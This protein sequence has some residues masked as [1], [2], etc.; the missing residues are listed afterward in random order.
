MPS[1]NKR[2]SSTTAK[3]KSKGKGKAPPSREPLPLGTLVARRYINQSKNQKWDDSGQIVEVVAIANGPRSYKAKFA[4]GVEPLSDNEA[5]VA[6]E[7]YRIRTQTNKLDI[8]R[9]P[10]PA[11]GTKI[12]KRYAIDEDGSSE[13]Y[14]GKVIAQTRRSTKVRFDDDGVEEDLTDDELRVCAFAYKYFHPEPG[15]AETKVEAKKTAKQGGKKVKKEEDE[16]EIPPKR[17]KKAKMEDDDPKP[18]AGKKKRLSAKQKLQQSAEDEDSGTEADVEEDKK[19]A[20]RTKRTGRKSATQKSEPEEPAGSEKNE[21]EKTAASSRQNRR[22]SAPKK[23]EQPA[24]SEQ[25]EE[26]KTAA[27]PNRRKASKKPAADE[28][29]MVGI[30]DADQII[31]NSRK[32]RGAA[33]KTEEEEQPDS[34]GIKR[35]HESR[36]VAPAK[37]KQPPKPQENVAVS[38]RRQT[39]TSL[40][41]ELDKEGISPATAKTAKASNKKGDKE[42]DEAP[43]PQED[44]TA[45]APKRRQ[46]RTSL[47]SEPNKSPATAKTAKAANKKG[48][49]EKEEP[50]T[51]KASEEPAASP[52][53]KPLARGSRLRSSSPVPKK[54]QVDA[55]KSNGKARTT[56]SGGESASKRAST[57]TPDA[58]SKSRSSSRTKAVAS[59]DEKESHDSNT[60]ECP[61][62]PTVVELREAEQEHGNANQAEQEAKAAYEQA[63]KAL[64]EAQERLR[65]AAKLHADSKKR[66]QRTKR[67]LEEASRSYQRRKRARLMENRSVALTETETKSTKKWGDDTACQA[68]TEV[69]KEYGNEV[70][71]DHTARTSTAKV[72]EGDNACESGPLGAKENNGSET[73]A[74]GAL[75]TKVQREAVKSATPTEV[76][77]AKTDSQVE[78]AGLLDSKDAETKETT[79]PPSEI[80]ARSE[81]QVEST[82]PGDPNVVEQ[83][84][85]SSPSETKPTT[86]SQVEPVCPSI[87]APKVIQGTDIID[88]A[89]PS[90]QTNTTTAEMDVAS[91]S[92]NRAKEGLEVEGSKGSQDE[93]NNTPQPQPQPRVENGNQNDE[94]S[95]AMV[96]SQSSNNSSEDSPKEHIMWIAAGKAGVDPSDTQQKEDV[97]SERPQVT[98]TSEKERETEVGKQMAGLTSPSQSRAHEAS[99]ILSKDTDETGS[100]AVPSKEAKSPSPGSSKAET[101]TNECKPSCTPP[102]PPPEKTVTGA[103]SPSVEAAD[104][105]E[106]ALGTPGSESKAQASVV[107]HD[108]SFAS[109]TND[110]ASSSIV[111][112]LPALGMTS[113]PAAVVQT[114]APSTA[115]KAEKITDAAASSKEIGMDPLKTVTTQASPET[116]GSPPVAGMDSLTAEGARAP[117]AGMEAITAAGIYNEGATPPVAD[118]ET[119]SPVTGV[120]EKATTAVPASTRKENSTTTEHTPEGAEGETVIKTSHVDAIDAAPRP[121]DKSSGPLPTPKGTQGETATETPYVDAIDSEPGPEDKT[122]AALPTLEGTE[123]ETM[124]EIPPVDAVDSAPIPQDKT[125]TALPTFE[126][127][128]GEAMS[129]I[130]PAGTEGETTTDSP[131]VYGNDAPSGPEGKAEGCVES[132]ADAVPI[133]NLAAESSM[134]MA[135]NA[136]QS[137]QPH[138]SPNTS[139][140]GFKEGERS[141]IVAAGEAAIHTGGQ[142]GANESAASERTTGLSSI[143][144]QLPEDADAQWCQRYEAVAA[145]Y[146]KTGHCRSST[147]DWWLSDQRISFHNDDLDPWKVEALDRVEINWVPI[148]TADKFEKGFTKLLSFHE[149][150][151]HIKVSATAYKGLFTWLT[152]QLEHYKKARITGK[153]S[154]RMTQTMVEELEMLGIV[155]LLGT[156]FDKKPYDKVPEAGLQVANAPLEAEFKRLFPQLQAHYRDFGHL[157]YLL[158]DSK[159][160]LGRFVKKQQSYFQKF[161]E[162]GRFGAYLTTGRIDLLESAGV[163]L[164]PAKEGT[165]AEQWMATFRQVEAFHHKYGH[166]CFSQETERWESV[167]RWTTWEKHVWAEFSKHQLGLPNDLSQERIDLLDGIKFFVSTS[168]SHQW[169]RQFDEIRSFY[170]EYGHLHYVD[171][172]GEKSTKD[173]DR[174]QEWDQEQRMEYSKFKRREPSSLTVGRVVL[175]S[176]INFLDWRKD[177]EWNKSRHKWNQSCDEIKAFF[178]KHGHLIFGEEEGHTEQDIKRWKVWTAK[179]RDDFANLKGGRKS[180]YLTHELAGSLEKIGLFL[181]EEEQETNLYMAWLKRF[182]ETRPIDGIMT[183]EEFEEASGDRRTALWLQE[184]REKCRRFLLQ[185]PK[186]PTLNDRLQRIVALGFDLGQEQRTHGE[187]SVPASLIQDSA[188]ATSPMPEKEVGDATA[189]DGGSTPKKKPASKDGHQ[190]DP[191]TEAFTEALANPPVNGTPGRPRVKGPCSGLTPRKWCPTPPIGATVEENGNA[192]SNTEPAIAASRRSLGTLSEEST[193]TGESNSMA[194]SAQSSL[195]TPPKKARAANKTR[196]SPAGAQKWSLIEKEGDASQSESYCAGCFCPFLH[197]EVA[198]L[199]HTYTKQG[200]DVINRYC[201]KASCISLGKVRDNVN[202][203]HID[204]LCQMTWPQQTEQMQERLR[205]LV[206]QLESDRTELVTELSKVHLMN[207]KAKSYTGTTATVIPRSPKQPQPA[208]HAK[209]PPKP[210]PKSKV[211]T[212]PPTTPPARDDGPTFRESIPHAAKPNPQGFSLYVKSMGAEVKYYYKTVPNITAREVARMMREKYDKLPPDERQQWESRGAEEADE[213]QTAAAVTAMFGESSS[214]S[215][216]GIRPYQRETTPEKTPA[217]SSESPQHDFPPSDEEEEEE[218]ECNDNDDVYS[219]GDT[220]N[221]EDSSVTS[222]FFDPNVERIDPENSNCIIM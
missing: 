59:K 14:E 18:A 203:D 149:E 161:K 129:D 122:S 82:T 102:V 99:L 35:K 147:L 137:S 204:E 66:V 201:C 120:D 61:E 165:K 222:S 139:L 117:A 60:A 172:L 93:K 94:I 151:G 91:R 148:A 49:K 114:P 112:T 209:S 25:N 187:T 56:R 101:N 162:Q 16:E 205:K 47:Q 4:D 84:K 95:H 141:E 146:E 26:K 55:E 175:L 85:P 7:A 53:K 2:R 110:Q 113:P 68:E 67:K 169:K 200:K 219:F 159:S 176:H 211:T 174:W 6:S 190:Q 134:S 179:L 184:Q 39:R 1:N 158:N 221:E 116:A 8:T 194:T 133:T 173:I 62:S 197:P 105:V 9:H 170:D 100:E 199:K 41:N 167:V 210:Q 152:A 87:P 51:A 40:Q 193:Q 186:A 220:D 195:P 115:P 111:S 12:S 127:T 208:S 48:G 63:E 17:A 50:A 138:T 125:S 45:V 157:D 118:M 80:D 77:A 140:G 52:D 215:T 216:G 22:K 98:R 74:T 119:T 154:T 54:N 64:K 150:H 31:N 218:S 156:E 81:S 97:E 13:W 75:K 189:G 69:L 89:S 192:A 121:Q 171:S 30:K 15:V 183:P 163:P 177:C 29:P 155:D 73:D 207:G 124:S 28:E 198:R 24:D 106:A 27:K 214:P 11:P 213:T 21:D 180:E 160:P 19:P 181:P 135:R 109:P 103:A 123:G 130:P 90:Q 206:Q 88:G 42:K 185:N 44:L 33:A 131:L 126:G 104:S 57:G 78:A 76:D 132:E 166:L 5:Q 168:E 34:R 23:S 37:K 178:E 92:E 188:R 196:Q 71:F 65:A 32:T 20:A 164:D 43:K 153:F 58:N 212:T 3:G 46:T 136:S 182:R 128:E 10:R 96:P 70:E 72:T 36:L 108:N 86:G 145:H 143:R 142:W 144:A 79:C 38:K 83:G 217:T 202:Q 191:F 107:E